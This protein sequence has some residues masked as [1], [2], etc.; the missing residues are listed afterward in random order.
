MDQP[1]EVGI[2]AHVDEMIYMEDGK[3]DRTEQVGMPLDKYP[4]F[5]MNPMYGE[6]PGIF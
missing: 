3:V 2:L 6:P 5:Q 4:E 1:I